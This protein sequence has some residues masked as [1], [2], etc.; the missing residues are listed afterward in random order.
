M[1]DGLA[2]PGERELSFRALAKFMKII[3][4]QVGKTA[5]ILG[6]SQH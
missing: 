6:Q 2:H 4:P 3:S 5:V 1:F